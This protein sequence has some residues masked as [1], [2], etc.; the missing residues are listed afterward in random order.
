[1]NTEDKITLPETALVQK[2]F[3]EAPDSTRFEPSVIA[4]A[5]GYSETS[6]T[7]MRS[8]GA[9]PKFW[10]SGRTIL[11]EKSEVVRWMDSRMVHVQN[12]AQGSKALRSA[13]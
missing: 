5:T 9:G 3:W 10:T 8:S 7:V 6:L 4:V 11:Y 2:T 12:S 13:A 1:M